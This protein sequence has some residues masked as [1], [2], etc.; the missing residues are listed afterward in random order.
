MKVLHVTTSLDNPGGAQKMLYKLLSGTDRTRF[1][2]EVISLIDVGYIGRKIERLGVPARGLGM[3][4]GVPNPI[5]VLQLAK[6]IRRDPPDVVQSWMHHADLVAGLAAKLAGN[7]P[8]AWGIRQSNFDRLTTKRLTVLTILACARMSHWLPTRIVCC[9]DAAQEFHA[10]LGYATDGM[11]VIPNGF[12][13]ATYKP[14]SAA[15]Q[16][17][18][19]EL[20]IPAQAP[21]IGLIAHFRPQKHHRNFMQAAAEFYARMPE[22]H[23]LLCGDGVTWENPELAQWLDANGM[24][25]SFHLLG[26]RYDIPRL[27]AALDVASTSASHAEGFPNSIGEA[28]ACGVPCVVTDVGD[29]SVIVGATGV[30]VAPRNPEALA[31]GWSQ[32]LLGMSREERLNLGLA[33][34]QRI[35]ERYGL[36]KIVGQYER[37]YESL[38]SGNGW[39][40]E[41]TAVPSKGLL[42]E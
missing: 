12:D 15:R 18:R 41:H 3:K 4:R 19:Q 16:S 40:A 9:S 17:V 11:V 14:D 30:V 5:A 10:Q 42:S 20:G 23:F 13:L 27:T 34:R 25:K 26:T 35:R 39:S 1:E 22:S 2:T 33:A 38:A 37:L 29:S 7:I 24:S 21:L 36:A 8:V 32:L 28:M 31:D 6:R